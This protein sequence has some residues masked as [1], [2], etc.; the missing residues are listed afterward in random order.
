[1]NRQDRQ[2]RMLIHLIFD[3][4]QKGWIDRAHDHFMFGPVSCG[5][6]NSGKT[7]RYRVRVFSIRSKLS[8]SILTLT[9]GY[10]P[11]PQNKEIVANRDFGFFAWLYGAPLD[12]K[13]APPQLRA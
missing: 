7:G 11:V 10:V 1:M 3:A 6:P 9:F 4:M 12:C 2:I 8:P 13:T 5:G